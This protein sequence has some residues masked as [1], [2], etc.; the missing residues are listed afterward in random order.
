MSSAW[1][2]KQ[3]KIKGAENLA[4]GDLHVMICV[5]HRNSCSVREGYYRGIEKIRWGLDGACLTV[6]TCLQRGRAAAV[7][8]GHTTPFTVLPRRN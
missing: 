2:S 8:L 1:Y 7:Y 3:K 4:A 6:P 5:G